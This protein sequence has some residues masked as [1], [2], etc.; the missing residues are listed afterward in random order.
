MLGYSTLLLHLKIAAVCSIDGIAIGDPN[1]PKTWRIDFAVGATK[2]QQSDAQA[3]LAAITP[4]A[5]AAADAAVHTAA[6]A[7]PDPLAT[8][9]AQALSSLP[10][11][12][13]TPS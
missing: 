8:A 4:L 10:T 9:K 6:A 1:N 11:A 2:Q 5:L 12:Q 7:L 13:I 3:A